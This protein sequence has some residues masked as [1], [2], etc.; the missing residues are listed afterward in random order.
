MAGLME[1]QRRISFVN[2][3][4]KQPLFRRIFCYGQQ[5]AADYILPRRLIRNES[6]KSKIKGLCMSY[7]HLFVLSFLTLLLTGCG[8]MPSTPDLLV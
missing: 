7:K 3:V 1:R 6:E 4:R 2:V 8:S 5:A